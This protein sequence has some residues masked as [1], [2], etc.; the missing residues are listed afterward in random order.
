M[1]DVR[2]RP[3]TL[4]LLRLPLGPLAPLL[5]RIPSVNT[6]SGV[7]LSPG[8]LPRRNPK[9]RKRVPG[10]FTKLNL[11]GN[12]LATWGSYGAASGQFSWGHDIGLGKDGAVYT[13]EV[14]N[15]LRAQKL[16]KN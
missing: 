14:R 8:C 2:R 13:A 16:V 1:A 11:Q 10:Q 6:G 9:G 5:V 4:G 7:R 12:V 15:N 3:V